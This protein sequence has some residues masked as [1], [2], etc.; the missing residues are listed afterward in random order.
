MQIRIFLYQLYPIYKIQNNKLLK[1]FIFLAIRVLVGQNLHISVLN[2]LINHRNTQLNAETKN[3][4]FNRHIF[5][6]L[7]RLYSRSSFVCNPE[8][9][10]C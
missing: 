10:T 1:I 9:N 3:Q 2:N 6:V 4:P 5:I 8:D 7:D